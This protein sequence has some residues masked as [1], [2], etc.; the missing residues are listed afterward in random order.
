MIALGIML[1]MLMMMD[2]AVVF[3]YW[4][5]WHGL[6]VCVML[7]GVVLGILI[8]VAIYCLADLDFFCL[9]IGVMVL[10]FVAY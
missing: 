2:V 6:V 10:A 7:L 1:L 8:G 9:L 3:V 5:K 4:R